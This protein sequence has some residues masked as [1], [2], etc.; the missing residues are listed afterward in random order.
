MDERLRERT[1]AELFGCPEADQFGRPGDDH[2][3][4]PGPELI[5]RPL[6]RETRELVTVDGPSKSSDL[7][8]ALAH[9]LV[10]RFPGRRIHLVVDN[11]IIH[12]SKKTQ[13]ALEKLDG[14]VIL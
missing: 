12:R 6:T 1:S 14:K 13:R 9:E 3:G 8:I 11:Y 2:F 10:R 4:R 5:G 7:F